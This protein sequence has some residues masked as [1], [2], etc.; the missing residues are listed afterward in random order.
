MKIL[1]NRLI[2]DN[3]MLPDHAE[4]IEQFQEIVERRCDFSMLK[5]SSVCAPEEI[6]I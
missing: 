5:E 6:S 3:K 4:R 2:D 1:I